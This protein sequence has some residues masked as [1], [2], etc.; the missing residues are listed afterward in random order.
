MAAGEAFYHFP[1]CWPSKPQ[2]DQARNR[3]LGKSYTRLMTSSAPSPVI[4]CS[5]LL[6]HKWTLARLVPCHPSR[7]QAVSQVLGDAVYS[8]SKSGEWCTQIS[9]NC[10]KEL[11]KLNKPFKFLGDPCPPQTALQRCRSPDNSRLLALW[12]LNPFLN[13]P[14]NE[15]IYSKLSKQPLGSCSYVDVNK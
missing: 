8:G 11:A 5:Q 12:S 15:N 10:L 6:P 2:F 1:H 3:Y 13:A 9:D 4:A 14:V 7:K